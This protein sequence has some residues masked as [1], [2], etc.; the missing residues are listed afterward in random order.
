VHYRPTSTGTPAPPEAETDVLVERGF[1]AADP[2]E[3]LARRPARTADPSGAIA[4]L[5]GQA[6]LAVFDEQLSANERREATTGVLVT[7]TRH[8]RSSTTVVLAAPVHARPHLVRHMRA[9]AERAFGDHVDVDGL[10]SQDGD[11]LVRVTWD[12]RHPVPARVLQLVGPDAGPSLWPAPCLVSPLVLYDRQEY[13]LNWR[14][15]S[16]VLIASPA[17]QGAEIP[18][19]AL[20]ASLASVRR[21]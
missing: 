11:V 2:V 20:V 10:V 17:G 5:L 14:S 15:V 13:D 9:A 16:N 12:Q 19:T 18:L 3:D 4:S 7:G 21:P 1:A 8:G 6:Y